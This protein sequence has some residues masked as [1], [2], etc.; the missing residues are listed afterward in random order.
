MIDFPPY[1]INF[2]MTPPRVILEKVT[3]D[4]F[5]ESE[6]RTPF[7]T[8]QIP[9]EQLGKASAASLSLLVTYCDCVSLSS[10]S[11]FFGEQ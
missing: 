3:A 5:T 2:K 8:P 1:V 4:G 7:G 6:E 9:F 10:S 11:Y